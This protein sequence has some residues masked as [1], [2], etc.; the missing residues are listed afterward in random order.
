MENTLQRVREEAV[1]EE[2]K[3]KARH[4]KLQKLRLERILKEEQEM[5]LVSKKAQSSKYSRD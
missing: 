5:R 3:E 4:E 2:A 1:E